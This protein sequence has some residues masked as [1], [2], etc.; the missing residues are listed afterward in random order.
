M[1]YNNYSERE[2]ITMYKK[3]TPIRIEYGCYDNWATLTPTAIIR[4]YDKDR[5]VMRFN[6]RIELVIDNVDIDFKSFK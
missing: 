1:W 3:N 4:P 5:T 2:V 6:D